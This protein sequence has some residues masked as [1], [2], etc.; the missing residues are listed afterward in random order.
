M[1][2]VSQGRIGQD[3]LTAM[4]RQD[5]LPPTRSR[6]RSYYNVYGPDVHGKL[7]YPAGTLIY[8]FFVCVHIFT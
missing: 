6:R 1:E 2:F 5:E 7:N 3:T 8:L 4:I